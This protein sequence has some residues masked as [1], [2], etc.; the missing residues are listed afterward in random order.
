MKRILWAAALIGLALDGAALAETV[1]VRTPSAEIRSGR[2]ALDTL[3]ERV[4]RGTPLEVLEREGRWLLV[5]TPQGKEGWVYASRTAPEKPE[6][7]DGV[8]A[9]LGKGFRGEAAETSASA[10]ARG[11][12]KVAEEHANRAGVRPADVAAINRMEK[13]SA[14]VTERRVEDFLRKGKVGEYR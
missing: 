6:G 3:V 8:L 13:F 2:T 10:G 9:R 1:Y 11:L 4:P 7:S 5:K 14:Q 12:D